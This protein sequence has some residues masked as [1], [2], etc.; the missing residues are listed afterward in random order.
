MKAAVVVTKPVNVEL[1]KIEAEI[2]KAKDL[3]RKQS[4]RLGQLL[5]I[6][7]DRNHWSP[8]YRSFVDY[9]ETRWEM[10]SS[11]AY[12]LIEFAEVHADISPIGGNV[13]NESQA[14]VLAPLSTTER[15]KVWKLAESQTRGKITAAD[16]RVAAMHVTGQEQLSVD[17]AQEL[18][19]KALD[20]LKSEDEKAKA[21]SQREREH[22][23]NAPLEGERRGGDIESVAQALSRTLE[24]LAGVSKMIAQL[25]RLG[26]TFDADKALKLLERLSISI[27][28]G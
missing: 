19:D 18:T 16:L 1:A 12:R 26:H 25:D 17:T 9:V 8:E 23:R 6:I 14:R 24:K 22:E 3:Y 2:V 10:D 11:Y 5:G 28:G 13:D 21:V 15:R 20:K 7:K 4:L 27:Q